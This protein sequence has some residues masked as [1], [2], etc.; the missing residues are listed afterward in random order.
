MKN[1]SEEYELIEKSDKEG[2]LVV[3]PNGTSS[4]KSGIF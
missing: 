2:F 3:F 4:F 1:M